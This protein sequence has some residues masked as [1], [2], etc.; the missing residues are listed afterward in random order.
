MSQLKQENNKKVNISDLQNKYLKEIQEL[1]LS[2]ASFKKQ[3]EEEIQAARKERDDAF[4][5]KESAEKEMSS[6]K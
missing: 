4:R 1:N 3:T 5:Q 6:W 2:L